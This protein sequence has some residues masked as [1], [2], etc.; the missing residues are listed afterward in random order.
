MILKGLS[1]NDFG[2]KFVPLQ[3]NRTMDAILI[4]LNEMRRSDWFH[5]VPHHQR[6]YNDIE[7]QESEQSYYN[8]IV[9]LYSAAV[10]ALVTVPTE[11]YNII[12]SLIDEVNDCQDNFE[13]PSEELLNSIMHDYNQ[14]NHQVRGLKEDYDYLYFVRECM[15]TQ[16]YFLD[17]FK[18]KLSFPH[19]Q[20]ENNDNINNSDSNDTSKHNEPIKGVKGLATYLKIGLTK[21]QDIINSNIL[22]ENSIAYRVGNGWNFNATKLDK[23]LEDNPSILYKRNK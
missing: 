17:S 22:Q 11:K 7:V 15:K 21:A 18:Q 9:P 3:K 6:K 5:D 4:F 14:S 2:E 13:V 19:P 8:K 10:M 12:Q 16:R 20:D 1:I 23:L